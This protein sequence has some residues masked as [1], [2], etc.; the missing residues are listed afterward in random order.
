VRSVAS[1]PQRRPRI[2]SID[3]R[4]STAAWPAKSRPARSSEKFDRFTN[5]ALVAA[6]EAVQQAGLIADDPHRFGVIIGT[7]MA[8]G[9]ARLELPAHLRRGADAAAATSI[10]WTM[11][12]APAS[13][14]AARYGAKASRTRWSPP[15][16]RA[17]AIGQAFEAIRN[18]R[19]DVMLAGGADASLT[20]GCIRAWESMRVLAIDNEHP[21]RRAGFQRGSQRAR[22]GGRLAV[23]VL[24]SFEHAE[25]R[26][27]KPLASSPDSASQRRRHVTDPSADGEMRAIRMALDGLS[28]GTSATSTRTARRRAPNDVTRPRP[29]RAFSARPPIASRSARPSRCTDTPWAQRRIEIACS[30]VGSTKLSAAQSIWRRP[31]RSAISTTSRTRRG[32]RR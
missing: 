25:G 11:Y 7:G 30:L 17:H 23:F 27:A 12:N 24:E 6:E 26:G 31:I 18:G 2:E 14:V 5:L 1:Q 22:A 21:K 15:A 4:C 29:S 3:G 32:R 16:R 10:A 8:G 28:A 19:A 13:A 9:D 20:V